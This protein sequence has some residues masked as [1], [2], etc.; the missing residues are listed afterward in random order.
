MTH[1]RRAVLTAVAATVALAMTGCAGGGASD[2]T[3]ATSSAPAG[4]AK[5][6]NLYAYAVPKVGFDKVIPAFAKTQ[7]GAGVEFQQSYGA[8]GDQS[9]KVASGAEAD[10]V[11][12]SVTPYPQHAI[13]TRLQCELPHGGIARQW[14][15]PEG[16]L[17]FLPMGGPAGHEVA[18]VWSL[19]QSL[20]PGWLASDEQ[21]F[22]TRLQAISQD[23][24]GQLEL[25]AERASWPLQQAVAD[26]WCG[27]LP[28][29]QQSGGWHSRRFI[30]GNDCCGASR[31]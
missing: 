17:A 1:T 4:S 30:K 29:A 20:V 11:N 25:V 22:T 14:F 3:G 10:V 16:I 26:R 8:S 27:A 9:R 31:P 19:E 18:V 13:A 6:L 12:F 21:S 2:V 15:T 28:D 7:Q 5:V 24:L 23:A